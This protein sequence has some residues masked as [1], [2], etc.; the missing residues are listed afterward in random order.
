M[1]VEL[2]LVLTY[3]LWVRKKKVYWTGEKQSSLPWAK[4][5]E[6]AI[7]YRFYNQSPGDPIFNA[8][9]KLQKHAGT[10]LEVPPLGPHVVVE[11]IYPWPPR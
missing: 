10:M 8:I 2:D 9:I 11:P 3:T 7:N 1:K 4:Q 5:N 6:A